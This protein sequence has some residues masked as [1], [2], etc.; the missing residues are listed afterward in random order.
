MVD[1]AGWELPVMYAS[2]VDEHTAT[3]TAAGLFDVS[4]MGEIRVTGSGAEAYLKTLIP[5]RME[6]LRPGTSMYSCFLNERGGVIDDLFVYMISP[7][8]YFLVVN[9]ATTEKDL[10]WMRAHLAS[11]VELAD[12]SPETSKI[13]LQGPRSSAILHK[14]IADEKTASLARFQFTCTA[15]RGETTMVSKSGYTGEA[16][17]RYIS[18]TR[19]PGPCGAISSTRAKSS[20]SSRRDLARAIRFA[21]RRAIRSTA[22]SSPTTSRRWNPESPGL[23]AHGSSMWGALRW[24]H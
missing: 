21:W 24:I 14:V 15:Y 3:R 5:T 9:A 13:D 22:T 12:L 2:I 20:A 10:A 17:T 7:E 23:S 4:H 16:D 1:F 6:K 19:L 11:G 18:Q 8:E